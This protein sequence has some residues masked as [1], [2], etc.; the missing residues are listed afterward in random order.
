MVSVGLNYLAVRSPSTPLPHLLPNVYLT[1][2]VI[3]SVMLERFSAL[4][5]DTL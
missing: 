4:K 1:L 2:G 5:R 3:T